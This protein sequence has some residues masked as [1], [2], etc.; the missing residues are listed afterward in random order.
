MTVN[1]QSMSTMLLTCDSCTIPTVVHT[2]TLVFACLPVWSGCLSY[3]CAH[4]VLWVCNIE[5]FAT[6]PNIYDLH[7]LLY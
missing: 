7:S 1:I 2:H 4:T 5:V 3:V 6:L